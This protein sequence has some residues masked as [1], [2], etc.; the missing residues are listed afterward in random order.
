MEIAGFKICTDDLETQ[1]QLNY[2]SSKSYAKAESDIVEFYISTTGGMPCKNMAL[3]KKLTFRLP[4]GATIPELRNLGDKIHRF[5][6]IECFQISIDRETTTV[7]MLFDF[8]DR[9]TAQSIYMN[10]SDKKLLATLIAKE[11]HSNETDNDPTCLRYKILLEYKEDPK[12]FSKYKSFLANTNIG[13]KGY[14]NLLDIL[15][16]MEHLCNGRTVIKSK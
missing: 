16:Y 11:L 7:N 8:V 1:G 15:N 2:W 12:I 4:D 9:E 13:T 14:A 6:G 5:F 10:T 3:I